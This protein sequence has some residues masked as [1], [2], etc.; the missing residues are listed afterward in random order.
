VT[1][2]LGNKF[3]NL[4]LSNHIYTGVGVMLLFLFCVAERV[5]KICVAEKISYVAKRVSNVAGKNTSP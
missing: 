2:A 1:E 5:S 3:K 4:S